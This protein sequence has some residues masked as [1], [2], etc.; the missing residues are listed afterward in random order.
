MFFFVLLL[1]KQCRIPTI[2][3]YCDTGTNYFPG[4]SK[5]S[6][7]TAQL[8]DFEILKIL[9]KQHENYNGMDIVTIQLNLTFN[10]Y[11][12]SVWFL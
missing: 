6:Y 5:S 7:V 8:I 10:T 2:L 12:F 1:K 4:I 3:F 9:I 11:W